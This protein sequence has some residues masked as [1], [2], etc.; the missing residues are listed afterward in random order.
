MVLRIEIKLECI[1]RA[2]D[3]DYFGHEGVRKAGRGG[4]TSEKEREG[5]G[6]RRLW[7]AAGGRI[8]DREIVQSGR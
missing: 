3:A 5:Q 4:V 8:D 1:G 2:R 6:D 7:L